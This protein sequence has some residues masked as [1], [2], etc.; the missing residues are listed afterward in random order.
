MAEITVEETS[1]NTLGVVRGFQVN[2]GN[3]DPSQGNPNQLTG[4]ITYTGTDGFYRNSATVIMNSQITNCSA[5]RNQ[6][7]H[8]IGHT[9]G[10]EHFCFNAASLCYAQGATI[11]NNLQCTALDPS[12]INCISYDLNEPTFGRDNPSA[13]DNQ[14]IKCQIYKLCPTPTPT[15]TR[16][17]ITYYPPPD[18]CLEPQDN[19]SGGY[20]PTGFAPDSGGGY[21]CRDAACY[22]MEQECNNSGG[23]WKGCT[24]GCYSPIVIDILGNGYNLT[25]GQ[26]GVEFD[27][28]GEGS[29]DKISW[30]SADSDDAWLALDRNGNGTIDSGIEL[31]GNFTLQAFSIAVKDRNGFL[32]LAIFDRPNKGG[33]GDGA[34]DYHD[35]IFNELRLWQDK[36]H[37]AVSEPNELHTLSSLDITTLEL[38]YHESKRT[39]EHGNRFKYR[40][41]VWD[42]NKAKVGRW[43]WDV[44]PVSQH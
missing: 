1:R 29:K 32:A 14:V 39:D 4:G 3:P 15:S 16:T 21:C 41:K 25:N 34:I 42:A 2:K 7:A 35:A 26:N 28:T 6:L 13:C 43:A 9:M 17:P 33:N 10:L 24:R 11:M 20:C 36:N 8:E 38:D 37:N 27:L 12:G 18:G 30:T 19:F 5:L 31:F 40:A 22:E 44:F 23:T